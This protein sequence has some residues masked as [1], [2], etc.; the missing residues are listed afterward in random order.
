MKK[1]GICFPEN[2]FLSMD[3]E[4]FKSYLL[5]LKKSGLYSFDMYTSLLTSDNK[6]LNELLMFLNDNDIKITFHYAGVRLDADYLDK[7]LATDILKQY[8]DDLIKVRHKLQAC[9]INYQTTVV[10]HA[11][12]YSEEYQKY[13][14]E[15]N[16]INIFK[17][18]CELALALNFDILIETLSYNHPSGNH[19]GDDYAEIEHMIETVNCDNFGICWDIGHTRLNALEQYSNMYLPRS[20]LPK[21]KFTHIHSYSV[22]DGIHE[23]QDHLPLINEM[24]REEEIG[25]LI[26]NE[27]NG[28]YSIETNTDNLKE[29]INVY[30]KSINI[31]S[32]MLEHIV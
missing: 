19:I 13:E 17:E 7:E 14:H 3:F 9:D 23:V 24:Y 5:A 26:K 12:N 25:Y 6:N 2:D 22:D 29:N 21:T 31:L 32:D 15:Q 20:I 16:Q 11:L 27:Y 4:E 28:I 1:I 18:L 30:L 8:K 10:F